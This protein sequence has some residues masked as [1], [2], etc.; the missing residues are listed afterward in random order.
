MNRTFLPPAAFIDP[1]GGNQRE[2]ERLLSQTASLLL[3]YLTGAGERSPL[4]E[5][6]AQDVVGARAERHAHPDLARAQRHRI[7]DGTVDADRR[8]HQGQRGEQPDQL[9]IETRLPKRIRDDL[10]HAHNA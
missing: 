10:F 7:G 4:P 2:V 5:D 9:Q 8:Q 6:E 1:R 3:P